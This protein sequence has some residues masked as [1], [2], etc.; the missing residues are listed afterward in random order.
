[1][2]GTSP[3]STHASAGRLAPKKGSAINYAKPAREV[4]GC[5]IDF[6]EAV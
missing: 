4:V 3:A 5:Y 1:M 6:D 2:S